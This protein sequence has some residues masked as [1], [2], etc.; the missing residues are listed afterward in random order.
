MCKQI[1]QLPTMLGPALHP[2]KD[3]THTALETMCN[4][5]A[6]PQQCWRTRAHRSNIIAQRLGDHGTKE[7]LAVVGS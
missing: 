2:G 5:H 4:E 1:H 7:M 6:W 3:T